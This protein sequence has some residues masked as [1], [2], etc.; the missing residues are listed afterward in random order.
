MTCAKNCKDC[1]YGEPVYVSKCPYYDKKFKT[2]DRTCS[3]D[4]KN[5]YECRGYVIKYQCNCTR[6]R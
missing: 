1:I 6:L 5:C 3:F 2:V 4:C